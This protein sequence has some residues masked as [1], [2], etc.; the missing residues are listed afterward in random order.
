M[1]ITKVGL[2]KVSI[3]TAVLFLNTGCVFGLFG[4]EPE[5]QI[6]KKVPK[7]ISKQIPK[8]IPKKVLK[9]I[10]TKTTKTTKTTKM[11]PTSFV[12]STPRLSIV[13]ECS[14]DINVK[15]SCQKEPIKTQEL[16][17]K[18]IISQTGGETHSLR[19][20]QGKEITIIEGPT[21]YIFPEFE[22]KVVILEMFGKNCSHCI[23][24]MPVMNK[25]QRRYRNHLKIVALQV[26]DKMSPLQ[27][28][29]LI[30]RHRINYPI[31]A[32]ETATNLQYH[33]QNTFGWTGIL[34]FIMVIKDGVTEFT[35]R[36][37]VSYKEINN[38]IRSILK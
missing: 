34:P 33:V 30:R 11:M 24:E 7:G 12:Q 13:A 35:Y 2:I 1:K 26:E 4:D 21:G 27:A 23:K 6:P 22:N 32:G 20:I 16:K 31:I 25:L 5:A 17:P 36:G 29:A 14:D 3:L 15:S 28:K 10:P 37:Q 18:Q 9:K 8:Q 38:D 19:S